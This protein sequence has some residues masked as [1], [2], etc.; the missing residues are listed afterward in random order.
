MPRKKKTPSEGE[1]ARMARIMRAQR[2]YITKLEQAILTGATRCEAWANAS[3]DHG[4]ST[5]QVEANNKLAA[6]LRAVLEA[7]PQ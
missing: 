6:E 5:H 7:K 2:R 3:R 4:W 1:G